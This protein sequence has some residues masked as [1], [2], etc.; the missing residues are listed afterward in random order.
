[1]AVLSITTRLEN[2]QTLIQEVETGGQAYG[3]G[4]RSLTRADLGMLYKQ[5][6]ALL[7]QYS[8]TVQG[9]ARNLI[10]VKDAL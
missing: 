2:I 1:M 3:K 4:N 8:D 10:K 6:A 5:E 9:R 7:E